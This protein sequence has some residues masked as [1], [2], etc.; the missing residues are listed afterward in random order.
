MSVYTTVTE[1]QLQQY[2]SLYDVGGLADF[3][4]IA[5]GMENTNYFVTTDVGDFVL[6]LF[7]FLSVDRVPFYLDLISFLSEK[8]I[9]CAH[10]VAD[11][12]GSYLQCL[13]GK[14]S[15]LF[16]RLSGQWV[17]RPDI[18]HCQALGRA[19]GTMHLAVQDLSWQRDNP[20]GNDWFESASQ[21]LLPLLNTESAALLKSELNWQ[22]NFC[23]DS[24]LPSGII[25]GDLF[26]DN[27][28][29]EGDRLTGIIDFYAACSGWL[30]YD[31][32]VIANDWCTDNQGELDEARVRHLLSAYHQVRPLANDEREA[33]PFMLRRAALQFW[34]SRMQEKH[35]G[36]SGEMALVKDPDE[37]RNMLLKRVA[38][39]EELQALW[40]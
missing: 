3:Q 9:P 26:R 31:L 11:V 4:G 30:I 24:T 14:P 21:Q 20:W 23:S 6:T 34:L 36:R 40:H 37:F 28:L 8:S 18:V 29:F 12:G 35:L 19:V 16:E 15:A 2:L 5:D 13:N 25:H 39:G 32:A 1:A 7:E 38:K 33:W 27:A 22:Q 17:Q 10:P